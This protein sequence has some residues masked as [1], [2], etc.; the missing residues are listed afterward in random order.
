MEL[1][2]RVLA[3][4]TLIDQGNDDQIFLHENLG[5]LL[6]RHC[7][8]RSIAVI[9]SLIPETFHCWKVV[10]RQPLN[11]LE[12]TKKKRIGNSISFRISPN[13]VIQV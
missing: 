12:K 13:Q 10:T 5:L 1:Y 11:T 9:L 7:Y 8:I 3:G 4:T 6:K 2:L